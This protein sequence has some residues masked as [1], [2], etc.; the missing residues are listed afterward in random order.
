MGNQ[1]KRHSGGKEPPEV[2]ILHM[3]V[4]NAT[5]S[6]LNSVKGNFGPWERTLCKFK[7]RKAF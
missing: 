3:V 5:L 6:L 4:N 1:G 7:Q 2:M